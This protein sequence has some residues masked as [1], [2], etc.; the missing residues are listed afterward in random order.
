MFES[1]VL[2]DNLLLLF[3]ICHFQTVPEIVFSYV[4]FIL[5]QKLRSLFALLLVCRFHS[6]SEIEFIC[7]LIQIL[8]SV[9]DLLIKPSDCGYF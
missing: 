2:V 4:V 3:L 7:L 8:F 9:E 1:L 6:I 5:F